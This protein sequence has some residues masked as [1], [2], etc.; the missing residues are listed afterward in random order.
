MAL[1][2]LALG[3]ATGLAQTGLPQTGPTQD[4]RS[5]LGLDGHQHD[6]VYATCSSTSAQYCY[7]NILRAKGG[8]M[9]AKVAHGSVTALNDLEIGKDVFIVTLDQPPPNS[10][11]MCRA[12][13]ID[14][15]P[16]RWGV[17][18]RAINDAGN[19]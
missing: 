12:M 4:D 18:A 6:T 5:T 13:A 1:A 17:L 15:S 19:R 14:S 8:V 16:C 9:P 7:F 3:P 2:L 11:S 10:I